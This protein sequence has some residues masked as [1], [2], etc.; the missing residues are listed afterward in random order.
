MC[1]L[2]R[3]QPNEANPQRGKNDIVNKTREAKQRV[4]GAQTRSLEME[5]HRSGPDSSY[6]LPVGPSATWF[7][8]VP[9]FSIARND[10]TLSVVVVGRRR[11]DDSTFPP[12][13]MFRCSLTTQ[14]SDPD[15]S[16]GRG[17]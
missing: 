2:E 13:S 17:S 3:P 7:Y 14:R 5:T 10:A 6:R 16:K 8:D 11:S 4:A 9:T 15:A 1:E 12:F